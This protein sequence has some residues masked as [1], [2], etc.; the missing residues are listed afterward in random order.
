M[1][2]GDLRN[3]RDYTKLAVNETKILSAPELAWVDMP[4]Y[5]DLCRCGLDPYEHEYQVRE[6]VLVALGPAPDRT[7]EY[8]YDIKNRIWTQPCVKDDQ[9]SVQ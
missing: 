6:G 3:V 7:V 4:A 5:T 9:K 8:E 1:K 2:Q